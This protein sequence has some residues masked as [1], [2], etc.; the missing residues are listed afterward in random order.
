MALGPNPMKG[1]KQKLYIWKRAC[2]KTCALFIMYSSHCVKNRLSPCMM[3]HANVTG[4]HINSTL[5]ICRFESSFAA[6][7]FLS[8]SALKIHG[9]NQYQQGIDV[10]NQLWQSRG[11]QHQKTHVF[12]ILMLNH[13]FLNTT[14][15][16]GGLLYQSIPV[17]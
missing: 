6:L 1:W 13:R 4:K 17:S 14:L 8:T 12:T 16:L 10:K 5:V 2:I 15:I 9:N 7:W 3:L 11:F